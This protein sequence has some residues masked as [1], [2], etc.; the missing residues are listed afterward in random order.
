MSRTA[1][2]LEVDHGLEIGDFE[3]MN[4]KY[5][6]VPVQKCKCTPIGWVLDPWMEITATHVAS[7]TCVSVAT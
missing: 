4:T 2:T 3:L 6:S 5:G 7:R 1:T